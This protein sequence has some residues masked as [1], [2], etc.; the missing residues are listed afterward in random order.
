MNNNPNTLVC[1]NHL[2]KYLHP[3]RGQNDETN[4]NILCKKCLSRAWK[5]ALRLELLTQVTG[6]SKRASGELQHTPTPQPGGP[7]L[8]S[9]VSEEPGQRGLTLGAPTG[10][11]AQPPSAALPERALAP[12]PSPLKETLP[13]PR[14]DHREKAVGTEVPWAGPTCLFDPWGPCPRAVGC[15]GLSRGAETCLWA[16]FSPRSEGSSRVARTWQ[17]SLRR[18]SQSV[19]RLLWTLCR[20]FSGLP[21]LLAGSQTWPKDTASSSDQ[22][23]ERREGWHQTPVHPAQLH[24]PHKAW[25]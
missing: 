9:C 12:R 5:S 18:T 8:G 2:S 17:L 7:S 16:V 24:P 14:R 21:A 6:C 1:E 15:W 19:R 3:P 25:S 10:A 11:V 22:G 20:L 4:A 23:C 13:G